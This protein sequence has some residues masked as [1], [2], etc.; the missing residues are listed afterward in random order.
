MIGIFLS[1]FGFLENLQLM[2]FDG[3]DG[4]V[5]DKVG[6]GQDVLF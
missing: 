4:Q 6:F 1:Y 2:Q 3:I 5:I